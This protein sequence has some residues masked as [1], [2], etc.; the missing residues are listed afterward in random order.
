MAVFSPNNV[1]ALAAKLR[2][3]E[4]VINRAMAQAI[5]KTATYTKDRSIR[6]MQNETTLSSAYLNRHLKTVARASPS[7]LRA[8]IRANARATLLTRYPHTVTRN[9][10][11]VQVNAKGGRRFIRDAFV[12]SGLR[13]SNTSG[14]ALRNKDAVAFFTRA[15]RDGE[16]A[17]PGK[18]AKLAA[19][20][21]KAERKPFGITI[22]HS[23]SV[24]QLF[25]SV[26]EDVQ[27]ET[28]TFMREEF[29]AAFNRL[30]R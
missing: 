4:A 24:N 5:N 1:G 27:P 8:I 15:L 6:R 3:T 9:G 21:A 22:L 17:T 7:N 12:Y 16:G 13:G 30:N 11:S 2:G 10:V 25:E 20:R 29:L 14:I 18:R 23:R 26:R 19:I 28:R